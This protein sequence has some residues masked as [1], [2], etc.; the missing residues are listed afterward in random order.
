MLLLL[1]RSMGQHQYRSRHLLQELLPTIYSILVMGKFLWNLR[2]RWCPLACWPIRRRH[3][4]YFTRLVN[5]NLFMI[6]DTVFHKA[7]FLILFQGAD[8][9]IVSML[10]LPRFHCRLHQMVWV[11][12][13]KTQSSPFLLQHFR[14]RHHLLPAFLWNLTRDTQLLQLK[15]VNVPLNNTDHLSGFSV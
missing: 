12:G 9:Q 1:N 8:I 3:P 2:R 13:K 4:M 5:P 6:A 15:I 11:H 14:F 7:K 10:I